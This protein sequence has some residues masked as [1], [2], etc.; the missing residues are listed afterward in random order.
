MNSPVPSMALFAACCFHLTPFIHLRGQPGSHWYMFPV[1]DVKSL[2]WVS[3]LC[4]LSYVC[5]L[6]ISTSFYK[7]IAQYFTYLMLA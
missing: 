1:S 4:L 6:P 3:A 7:C 2:T 5:F